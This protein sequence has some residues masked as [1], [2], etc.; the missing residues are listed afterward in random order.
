MSENSYSEP[1]QASQSEATEDIAT[2]IS[3]PNL[4]GKPS[5]KEDEVEDRGMGG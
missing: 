3:A 4:E 5:L 2:S 1:N